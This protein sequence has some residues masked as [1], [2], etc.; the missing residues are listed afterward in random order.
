M[1]SL[2]Q[3]EVATVI[4]QETWISDGTYLG[5][6]TPLLDRADIIVRMDVPWRVASYRILSR[7]VRAEI[8]RNNRF[9]GW[10]AVYRFW[11]WSAAYYGN[12][13][14]HGLNIW[15]TPETK[16]TLLDLLEPF[17]EK[18]IVCRDLADVT[19]VARRLESQPA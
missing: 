3:K 4:E 18:V 15:G 9:P 12:R 19:S 11:R 5:W 6:A 8:A 14:V 1:Q 10:R 7:H 2:L 13:N 17:Q 16:A